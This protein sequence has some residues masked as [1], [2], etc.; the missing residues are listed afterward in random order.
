LTVIPVKG[1]TLG[2]SVGLT[3]PKYD[4]FVSTI[5]GTD[6]SDTPFIYTPKQTYTFSADYE[7][8]FDGVGT[9]NLHADY[10]YRTKAYAVPLKDPTFTDAQNEALQDTAKIPGYGLLNGRIAFAFDNPNLELAVYARN[11]TKKKYFTRLLALE[12]TALGVT[13]Y[14]PGDPRTYGVSAT[15]RF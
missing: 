14:G 7:I 15:W 4:S 12:G 2:A 6:L 11:I 13:A 9:L 8:P 1:L 5:D 10:S 3:Y